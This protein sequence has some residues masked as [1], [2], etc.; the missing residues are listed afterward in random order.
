MNTPQF[1]SL[2]KP[3]FHIQLLLMRL[4]RSR[5]F[6]YARIKRALPFMD[7]VIVDWHDHWLRD[8][9]SVLTGVCREFGDFAVEFDLKVTGFSDNLKAYADTFTFYAYEEKITPTDR[10]V[11]LIANYIETNLEIA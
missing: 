3:A 10:E 11:E 2:S 7:N 8:D 9:Y 5:L 4:G 6:R 1:I